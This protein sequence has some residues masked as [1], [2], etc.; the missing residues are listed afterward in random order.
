MWHFNLKLAFVSFQKTSISYE[1]ERY[2]YFF[3][4]NLCGYPKLSLL[5]CFILSYHTLELVQVITWLSVY[6]HPQQILFQSLS[7]EV[8]FRPQSLKCYL[9][10]YYGLDFRVSRKMFFIFWNLKDLILWS[11][12]LKKVDRITCI[13]LLQFRIVINVYDLLCITA[14]Q[15]QLVCS[16]CRT[17]LL[18]PRGAANVCCAV[19]NVVTTVPP[20]GMVSTF[21]CV[22]QFKSV[23]IGKETIYFLH[24]ARYHKKCYCL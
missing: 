5:G 13:L 22:Y 21:F 8:N 3:F 10:G 18:Y 15:S 19:C 17:I 12:N 4:V 24:A 9:F 11:W 16:G 7:A 1:W 6:D 20:P 14:M 23:V 2:F